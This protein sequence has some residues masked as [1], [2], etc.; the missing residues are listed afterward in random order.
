MYAVNDQKTRFFQSP[1]TDALLNQKV[2][3]NNKG[4][5][6]PQPKD[7]ILPVSSIQETKNLKGA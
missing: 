3:V 5:W 6:I 7:L 4:L 1:S 2:V